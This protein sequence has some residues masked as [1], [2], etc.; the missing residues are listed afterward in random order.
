[1]SI[2]I[3]SFFSQVSPEGLSSEVLGGLDQEGVTVLNREDKIP[4]DVPTFIFIGTGGT[5]NDVA[6]FLD[7]NNLDQPILLLSYDE[8][9]SL[10][11]AMEIRAYLQQKGMASRIIHKPLNQLKE[12]LAKWAQY[13]K[14]K[15]MLR[16]TKIGI[17][18][19]PSSWLIASNVDYELVAKRWGVEF[20]K[21]P[22]SELSMK[23]ETSLDANFSERIKTFRSKAKCQNVTDEAVEK[24]GIVAQRLNK[25]REKNEL[26]AITVQC[27][28][29][30]QD[31]NISGCYALSYLNDIE[32]FVAGCEGD[33]PATFTMLLAKM[34]TGTPSFMANVA[35]V[36]QSFNTAVFAHC[37]VPTGIADE[38]EI[39]NHF[40]TGLSVGIRGSLPLTDVT[41]VKVFGE[42]L[43]KYWISSGTIIDNLVNDKGCR[44][45]IRVALDESVDYFL[46]E[47]LANHHIIILGDHVEAFTDF[48]DFMEQVSG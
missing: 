35:S 9:N 26:A 33:I 32:S 4:K 38:Y 14:V 28:Q 39:T 30:L 40:E 44:T 10:P 2:Q 36:D 1:M 27:F 7:I 34:L 37:T 46:E 48:F 6:Q 23:I 47:S 20:K 31:T 29:L 18:G 8:R 17:V 3:I 24:A 42:D 5:E 15:E 19:E 43:S 41:I 12:L 16:S 13:Y 11:A 21:I 25:I 22:I 45:Q